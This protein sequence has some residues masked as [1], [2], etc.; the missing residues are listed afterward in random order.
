MIYASESYDE[1][2]SSQNTMSFND[3]EVREYILPLIELMTDEDTFDYY[4]FVLKVWNQ[5]VI[6]QNRQ[7]RIARNS[8]NRPV[9]TVYEQDESSQSVASEKLK[10]F[11]M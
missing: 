9:I 5:E 3:I 10:V 1:E 11:D 8:P 7:K 6:K 4:R 2:K